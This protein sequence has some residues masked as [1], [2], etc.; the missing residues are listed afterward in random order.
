VVRFYPDAKL[1]IVGHGPL[2]RDLENMARALRVWQNVVFA[3]YQT[4]AVAHTAM[5]DIFVLP[6]LWE[7]TPVAMME[8]MALGKPVIATDV[9][10]VP[11]IVDHYENGFL[12]PP[13][14]TVWLY[15]AILTLL[16]NPQ[17]CARFGENARMKMEKDFQLS[18]MVNETEDLYL[19]LTHTS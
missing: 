5:C 13:G 7:G 14:D 2:R 10:G 4:D 3:G 15:E 11:E 19:R 17:L 1:V 18:R 9:G 12:V 6:S 8:A 16:S